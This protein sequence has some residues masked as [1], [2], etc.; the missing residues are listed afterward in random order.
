MRILWNQADRLVI[1]PYGATH[2]A[3]EARRLRLVTRSD[4]QVLLSKGY[5]QIARKRQHLRCV[6]PNQRDSD[7]DHRTR[8]TDVDTRTKQPSIFQAGI[9][10]GH[11]AKG[12]EKTEK[13]PEP[14][15][16]PRLQRT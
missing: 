15:D 16:L 5:A 10:N 1:P 6:E 9:G 14:L 8:R 13:F 4:M 2:L 7:A 3:F 11:L 12:E